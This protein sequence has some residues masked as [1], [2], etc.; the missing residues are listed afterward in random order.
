MKERGNLQKVEVYARIKPLV[1][2]VKKIEKGLED[3]RQK[4]QTARKEMGIPRW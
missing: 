4:E 1:D 3:F 2:L